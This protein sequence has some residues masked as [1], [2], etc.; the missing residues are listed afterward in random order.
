MVDMVLAPFPS[1][2][3]GQSPIFRMIV[4]LRKGKNGFKSMVPDLN[5]AT[6]IGFTFG[7]RNEDK[8]SFASKKEKF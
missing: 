4:E 1:F 3:Q 5:V 2:V 8:F 7:Q 6:C